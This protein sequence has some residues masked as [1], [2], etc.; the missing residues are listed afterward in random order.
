[1][2]SLLP[3]F[4]LVPSYAPNPD[5]LTRVTTRNLELEEFSYLGREAVGK[6]SL[7]FIS[8]ARGT[9]VLVAQIGTLNVL[10]CKDVIISD[11]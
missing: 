3:S 7:Y 10:S 11:G 6:K 1:M 4:D 8:A 5:S 9:G 2:S